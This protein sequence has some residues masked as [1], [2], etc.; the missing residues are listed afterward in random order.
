M[1]W[2]EILAPLTQ[3]IKLW[4]LADLAR[5]LYVRTFTWILKE[6][7]KKKKTTGFKKQRKRERPIRK[8]VEF[9]LPWTPDWQLLCPRSALG[10]MSAQQWRRGWS[11]FSAS[12]EHLQ[13][14]SAGLCIYSRTPG[15]PR[16][17]D[18]GGWSAETSVPGA[19]PRSHWAFPPDSHCPPCSIS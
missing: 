19:E 1:E 11:E 3:R 10:Q 9:Q 8:T 15:S 13:T 18:T 5:P 7:K 14:A 2:L 17:N 6:K 16:W 12:G 4:H